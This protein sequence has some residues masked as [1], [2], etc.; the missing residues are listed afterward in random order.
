MMAAARTRK[1]VD[2]VCALAPDGGLVPQM[3]RVDARGTR[4][5]MKE[6]SEGGYS[7]AALELQMAA[8]TSQISLWRTG[9]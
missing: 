9:G 6:N 1:G 4:T 7:D 5:P 3:Y 8:A 2:L